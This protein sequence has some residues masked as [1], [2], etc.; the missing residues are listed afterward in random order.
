[1]NIA[2]TASAVAI[3]VAMAATAFAGAAIAQ[4]KKKGCFLAGGEAT[5]VTGDLARFMANA[6]LNNSI[7][8][9]SATASGTVKMTCKDSVATVYCLAQQR[10][11]K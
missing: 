1:M 10:A 2:K 5:M 3:V 7:K 6:A 9:A 11:C 4:E 8:G